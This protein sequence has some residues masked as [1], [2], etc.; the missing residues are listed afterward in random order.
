VPNLT[1]NTHAIVLAV[2]D[3]ARLVREKERLEKAGVRLVA[4][5]EPS[6]PWN[7]A[8]MALGI[9][10]GRREVLRRFLSSLA[11]LK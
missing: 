3:E 8:L 5:R 6:P 1:E 11:L 9:A 7:N 10:P 2:P 4:I